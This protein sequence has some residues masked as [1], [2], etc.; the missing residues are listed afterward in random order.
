MKANISLALN[1]ILIIAVAYLFTQLSGSSE[2]APAK[3]S[4][5]NEEIEVN[6]IVYL[7]AD[8]L[9]TNYSYF[10][11]KMEE[12]QQKEA[13]ASKRINQQMTALESEFKSVQQKIQQG[14][15]TPNQIAQEEQRLT[16]KQQ[17]LLGEQEQIGKSLRMETQQINAELQDELIVLMDSL[18]EAKGYDYILQFGQG[19]GVLSA[20]EGYDITNDV[21][22]ILN[23]KRGEQSEE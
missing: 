18:R 20:R 17:Q 16:Q 3:D 2:E 9:L 23:D 7:N 19:S 5:T 8:T 6:E 13:D 22:K 1:A 11:S 12:L 15:L 14:L 21:L 4:V 10:R